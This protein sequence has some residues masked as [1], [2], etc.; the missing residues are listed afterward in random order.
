M[1]FTSREIA[2]LRRLEILAGKVLKGELRGEREFSRRGPLH[3]SDTVL[4]W[5]YGENRNLASVFGHS[6]KGV[7][8]W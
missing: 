3:R 6:V 4:I 2:H 5:R 8:R 1:I 7:V